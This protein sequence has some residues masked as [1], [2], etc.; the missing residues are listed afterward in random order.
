MRRIV[1]CLSLLLALL[2]FPERAKAWDFSG[3]TDPW[4]VVLHFDDPVATEFSRDMNYDGTNKIWTLW[5]TARQATTSFRMEAFYSGGSHYYGNNGTNYDMA[6]K[7]GWE[8]FDINKKDDNGERL[9]ISNLKVGASYRIDLGQDGAGQWPKFRVEKVYDNFFLYTGV[10]DVNVKQVAEGINTD[11]TFVF[12][13]KELT[14]GQSL[15]LSRVGGETTWNGMQ[16]NDARFNP[17]GQKNIPG[18]G[19]DFGPY[20][21]GANNGGWKTTAAGNYVITVDWANQKLSAFNQVYLYTFADDAYNLRKL[22]TS[23]INANDCACFEVDLTENQYLFLSAND[24]TS[25]DPLN[26]NGGRIAPSTGDV[27]VPVKDNAIRFNAGGGSWKATE[28]GRYIIT[29]D[30]S[31]NSFSAVKVN[32]LYLYKRDNEVAQIKEITLDSSLKSTFPATIADNQ[33]LFLSTN[34]G[35]TT[36][37]G[38][39]QYNGRLNPGNNADVQIPALNTSFVINTGQNGSWKTAATGGGGNYVFTVDY[40]AKTLSAV[41]T[42]Y[43]YEYNAADGKV[44]KV[45]SGTFGDNSTIATFYTDLTAGRYLMLSST[46]GVTSLNGFGSDRFNPNGQDISIP[47]E[48][49][50]FAINNADKNGSWLVSKTGRYAITVDWA[51]QTLS[52]S[53][54][55]YLYRNRDEGGSNNNWKTIGASDGSINGKY[56]FTA[57][58]QENDWI[59]LSQK[60]NGTGWGDISSLNWAPENDTDVVSN[61]PYSFRQKNSGA[62]HITKAGHYSFTV[63]WVHKTLVANEIMVDMPLTTADF[64]GNKKHYFLVGERLGEWHLQP[65]WEFKEVNGELV[66]NNRYFYNG[67]FAV[68]VVD[69]YDDYITHTFTYYSTAAEFNASTLSSNALGSGNKY[70]EFKGNTRYNPADCFYAKF[71]GN[72]AY[73]S[74]YGTFMSS[75]KVTLSGGTPT[76]ITFTKGSTTDAAK[77]RVFTLVGDHIIN[78]NYN[79]VPG[80][81]T[82]MQNRD[83]NGWMDSWIQYNPATNKPYVDGN[84]EYLYHTSFTPDYLTANPVQFNIGLAGG[85]EFAYT[86][87]NIQFVEYSNLNNLASDPYKAFYTAFSGKEKIPDSK[88]P[89]KQ[90]EGYNFKVKVE[91]NN[92][93]TTP[94]DNWSCYVIRDVWIAGQIKFWSGWGG[95][96]DWTDGGTDGLAVWHGPN[97][98]PDIDANTNHDVKGYDINSGLDAVLYKNVERRGNTNYKISDGTP[99]YFNRVILWYNNADGVSKSYIQFIQESAGPAIFAQ[100]TTNTTTSKNNWIK[101]NWY[102]NESQQPGGADALVKSYEIRRYRIVDGKAI[103]AGVVKSED[104]SGRKIKVS[105][106]YESAAS[107]LSDITTFTDKGMADD[108]GFAPGLYEY[109]I[110][111]VDEFGG[112]KK[113]TSNR[114]AI[115]DDTLVTPDAVPMQLVELRDAYA[116]AFGTSHAAASSVLGTN[117]R[118]LTYRTNDNDNFY[119]MNIT[120]SG[121]SAQPAEAELIDAQKAIAFLKNHP[122]K[123]FW[124]S[125]YYVRCLDYDQYKATLQTYIDNAIIKEDEVPTPTVK[126]Y[127]IYTAEGGGTVTR[128]RGTATLFTFGN[129]NYYSAVVKRGGNLAN[130]TL[131]VDLSYT[132]T[133]SDGTNT[134]ATSSATTQI[135][136][137]MPM[138]RDPK[139]RYVYSQPEN[140]ASFGSNQW[141]KINVPAFNWESGNTTKDVYVKLDDNFDPRQLDLQIDFTRP[142]VNS[143][144]YS[145]YNI[146]YA[147]NVTNT[148]LDINGQIVDTATSGTDNRYR[149]EI[150]GMN[151]RDEVV[152]TVKITSTTYT[153]ITESVNNEVYGTQVASYG[154]AISFNAPHAI[155]A[156][157]SPEGLKNV[158]LGKVQRNDGKW[159][160]MYK[161][162]ES[163]SDEPAKLER[164]EVEEKYEDASAYSST[165]IE[166]RYY[167]IEVKGAGNDM[168]TYSFLVP[169]IANHRDAGEIK[170]SWW[171]L[172]LNDSDPLI[173]TYIA[174][175]FTFGDIPEIYATAIYIF[176]R[177]LDGKSSGT[178]PNY[179]QLTVQSFKVN[180]TETAASGA[181]LAPARIKENYTNDE[182]INNGVGDLPKTSDIPTANVVDLGATNSITGYGSSVVKGHTYQ[183]KNSELVTGAE[184]IGVDESGEAVY[185]NLRGMRIDRPTSTGV[186]IRVTPTGVE[187]V[188]IK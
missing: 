150:K 71:D 20:Y 62:W 14:N 79:N 96:V 33:Y 92:P 128:D 113:A 68:G 24:V 182:L 42:L 151:A 85:N 175:D 95:N 173:G 97:G 142:N 99:V 137:V 77:Q 10:S 81:A 149:Y 29:L 123:Y 140:T 185:Y 131:K 154:E 187:K 23:A 43:L 105:Q 74:G 54:T 73:Y 3:N 41:K 38:L 120:G 153:P 135:S 109:V 12:Y 101:S 172:I 55:I 47:A 155:E 171:G 188:V 170:T 184:N 69:N 118:Y 87:S 127:D 53:S 110:T 148:G 46:D 63:D 31:R 13:A 35:V 168:A 139:Y 8:W 102:L 19:I 183:T 117:K 163:F 115:Y 157:Y 126:V 111:V 93:E 88:N 156:G 167:L 112:S 82:T 89:Q 76:G 16:Y 4:R 9:T 75:I 39:A 186:Y 145:R 51:A 122:D 1:L 86:S 52:A 7:T 169:H 22:G 67:G 180:G 61:V 179:T 34:A 57:Y 58:F 11:G 130:A 15:Y 25:L 121:T 134:T 28:A 26:N 94:S 40:A 138:P 176:K 2:S 49:T 144:I 174:E 158:H 116:D 91:C 146:A 66:L 164:A 44:T 159:D 18:T 17:S 50:S 45:G 65:E 32:K 27:N 125:D 181:N 104:I 143:E 132:Y 106:L 60:A 119:V 59:V 72:D 108:S 114:V 107:S 64:A 136:P 162:H 141:G 166:P 147:L 103:E 37:A 90:G 70:Q 78:S 6:T 178:D 161:G 152:P 83:R 56:T 129:K 30:M 98:G 36:W 124:T 84:G 5:F 133:K 160:W 100:V 177:Q 165:S 21:N 80:I 48:N